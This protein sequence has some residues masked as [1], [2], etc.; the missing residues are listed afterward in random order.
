MARTYLPALVVLVIS[1][2]LGSVSQAQIFGGGF[3]GNGE[4]GTGNNA[5][6]FNLLPILNC[7]PGEEY[8]LDSDEPPLAIICNFLLEELLDQLVEAE[9]FLDEVFV[10][11]RQDSPRFFRNQLDGPVQI[12]IHF[13][14]IDGAGGTLAV[15][16]P[17]SFAFFV[18]NPFLRLP[19]NRGVRDWVIS[20]TGTITLD[21]DDV[22][23]LLLTELMIDVVV[24]ESFHAMG[25]T[26]V[27]DP[28]DDPLTGGAFVLSNLTGPT[29]GF[30]QINFIG[31]PTGINDIGYGITEFRE[32][33]GNIL[34][35]Y[36]PLSQN[37]GSAHLSPFEPAFVRFDEG[38]Q[39]T[40]IP[41]APP[42]GI[43]GIM[44][45]SLQ[46][47]FADLGFKIRGVNAPGFVDIDNDG[48][49]DDPV[50]INPIFGDHND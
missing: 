35:T 19:D 34:A 1:F 7:Q 27:D 3:A 38:F 18:T 20:R 43:Q 46:G 22:I 36:I 14:E 31:D 49:A 17:R 2:S 48:D 4:N 8:Q 11:Y 6:D 25:H 29:G 47:M 13:D 24:H 30:G 10:G 42:P 39:D 41:F 26:G 37:D 33:S 5:V 21:V 28:L 15:A 45:F 16:G 40:F 50:I 23:P 32:E 9:R 44:S 12:T